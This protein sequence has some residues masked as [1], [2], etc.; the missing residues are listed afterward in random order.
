MTVRLATPADEPAV[1]DLLT[2]PEGLWHDNQ[3][4][5]SYSADKVRERIRIATEGRGG[6]IG[7]IDGDGGELAGGVGLFIDFQWYSEQPY[8]SEYFLFVRLLYRSR[9]YANELFRF[10]KDCRASIANGSGERFPL[11]TSVVSRNRLKAK[12]RYWAKHADLIGGVYVV[13]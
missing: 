2:G 8:L 13:E 12:M 11:V 4:G 3:L 7:V 10:A 9:G 6:I 5:F 1:F